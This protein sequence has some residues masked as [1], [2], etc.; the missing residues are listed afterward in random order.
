MYVA[1]VLALV[2]VVIGAWLAVVGIQPIRPFAVRK[3]LGQ[4]VVVVY[5]SY[6]EKGPPAV[7]GKAYRREGRR[8]R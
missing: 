3:W 8:L 4:I 2:V 7:G 6:N 5:G 1:L